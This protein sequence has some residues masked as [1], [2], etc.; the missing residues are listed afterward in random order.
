M[1][2]LL[3]KDY[4][5]N[6]IVGLI[7]LILVLLIGFFL[8]KPALEESSSL[9]ALKARLLSLEAQRANFDKLRKEY[10]A[11]Q[12][13][14]DQV[15]NLFIDSSTP[16]ELIDFLEKSAQEAGFAIKITS[17]SLSKSK[18]DVWPA[19][20]FRLSGHGPTLAFQR[21]LEKVDNSPYLM[22]PVSFSLSQVGLNPGGGQKNPA[23]IE[24]DMDLRVFTK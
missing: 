19:T 24:A 14:I 21:F 23:E 3:K 10:R 7:D 13:Q 8:I 17:A 15:A 6:L 20:I 11:A 18:A 22:A 4:L 5:A 1:R 12:A 16:V 2:D 9:L